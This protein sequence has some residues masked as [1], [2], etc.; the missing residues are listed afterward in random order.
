MLKNMRRA[1][2]ISA[3]VALVGI[4]VAPAAHAA[5]A[6]Q[7]DLVWYLGSPDRSVVD[8]PPTGP[9]L[10]DITVTNGDVSELPGKISIGFYST[11]QTTVRVNIPGGREIRDVDLAISAPGGV[12]YATALIRAN[13][14]TPPTKA[15]TFAIVGGTGKYSGVSGQAIHSGFTAQGSKIEFFFVN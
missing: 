8:L 6:P 10:G 2:V 1:A 3:T 12:I 5:K 15:Q 14:G 11:N 7:P 4:S 9:S 13:S